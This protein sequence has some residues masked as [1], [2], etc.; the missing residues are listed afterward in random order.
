[1]LVDFDDNFLNQCFNFL[2][3]FFE[4]RHQTSVE[5]IAKAFGVN[6]FSAA[7]EEELNQVLAEFYLP[8][9]KV[10]LLEI[11]SPAERSGE[12]IREYFRYLA[13]V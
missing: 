12:G 9:E 8:A 10:C 11:K 13:S 3:P 7:S 4:A 6:Y 1:M 2:E 5:Y